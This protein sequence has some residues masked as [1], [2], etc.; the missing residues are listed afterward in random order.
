MKLKKITDNTGRMSNLGKKFCD[1]VFFSY[2]RNEEVLKTSAIFSFFAK[3][4][5]LLSFTSKISKGISKAVELSTVVNFLKRFTGFLLKKS[6]RFYG[7][8]FFICGIIIAV[9][10]AF[11][12]VGNFSITDSYSVKSILN[13]L[14]IAVVSTVMMFSQR[15]LGRLICESRF[16]SFLYF[17]IMCFDRNEFVNEDVLP[18]GNFAAAFAGMALGA[19]SVVVGVTETI[20]LIVILFITAA[21]LTKPETGIIMTFLILPFSD[22]RLLYGMVILCCVSVLFKV[23]RNKRVLKFGLY[24]FAV[25]PVFLLVSVGSF[26]GVDGVG[27]FGAAVRFLTLLFFGWI[28][29]NTI[30]TTELVRKCIK[31]LFVSVIFTSSVGIII[32]V[33][34]LFDLHSKH[35]IFKYVGEM[36]S[37]IPFASGYSC[38]ELAV[39]MFPFCFSVNQKKTVSVVVS[40]IICVLFSVLSFNYSIWIACILSVVIYFGFKNPRI[41]LYIISFCIVIA[42]LNLVFPDIFVIVSLF[43]S[44]FTD[45]FSIRNSILGSKCG[46][47]TASE[48]MYAGA[49]SGESTMQHVFKCLYGAESV[50]NLRFVSFTMRF[51]IQ[52]GI[53]GVLL[54]FNMISVFVNNCLS[55]CF[56]DKFCKS[57]LKNHIISC[58]SSVLAIIITGLLFPTPSSV[59][60]MLC[61]IMMMNLSVSVRKGSKIEYV[62]EN[63]ELLPENEV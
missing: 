4:R 31:A 30:R 55:L 40:A 11:N 9:V 13:G 33:F 26:N 29:S 15:S 35:I 45:D 51:I 53:L 43:I 1:F 59:H 58:F 38:A 57:D 28:L 37:G 25:L 46:I 61:L 22:I 6:L 50:E 3:I 10:N 16:L 5:E 52:Y 27:G 14:L 49:G 47:A 56:F 2:E 24:D 60:G 36:L 63:Y 62:P 20:A 17:D 8:M 19:I 41:F 23:V 34:A 21:V 42:V 7:Y 39:M 48:F 12:Y 54:Y 32:S 44:K 18:S